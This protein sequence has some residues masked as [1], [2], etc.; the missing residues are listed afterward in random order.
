MDGLKLR[1]NQEILEL[2]NNLDEIA[3]ESARLQKVV[4]NYQAQRTV[5]P[6]IKGSIIH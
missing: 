4:T 6:I 5:S 3:F 2:Q 1:H